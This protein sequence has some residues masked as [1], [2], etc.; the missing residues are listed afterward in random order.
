M[1]EKK[2]KKGAL[3]GKKMPFILSKGDEIDSSGAPGWTLKG[4]SGLVPAQAQILICS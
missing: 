3:G 2:G 1:K 4:I